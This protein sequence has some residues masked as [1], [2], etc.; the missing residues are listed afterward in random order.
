MRT[1]YRMH[2]PHGTYFV[3]STIVEW[4]PVF[5][6]SACCDILVNSL[7]HSREKRQLRIHAWVIM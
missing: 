4:L 1:R 2:E 7:L 3:T 6:T 5:T